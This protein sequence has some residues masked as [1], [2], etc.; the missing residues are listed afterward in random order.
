MKKKWETACI[1]IKCCTCECEVKM[2]TLG[3]YVV[4][5]DFL[6]GLVL[7]LHRLGPD[8]RSVWLRGLGC[9]STTVWYNANPVV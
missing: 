2:L 1:N 3:R 7:I 6:I 5:E 8:V 4:G 9:E